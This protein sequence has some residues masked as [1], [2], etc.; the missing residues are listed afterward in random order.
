MAKQYC[1]YC[2]HLVTG[3][4]IWCEAHKRSY[5]ESYCKVT[6]NCSEFE[7]N[8]IDAFFENEAGYKP[9]KTKGTDQ[10]IQM[11]MEDILW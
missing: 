7:L 2:A 1:R 9:R 5:S 11:T 6:N 8:P 4:G 10:G 3:N